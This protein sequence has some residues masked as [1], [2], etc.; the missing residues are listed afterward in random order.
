M[1]GK[2]SCFSSL[3]VALQTSQPPISPAVG[4]ATVK[5][6]Y[7]KLVHVFWH[8]IPEHLYSTLGALIFLLL[9]EQQKGMQD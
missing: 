6:I 7:S 4:F 1:L 3:L 9:F 5:P 2:K 8:I